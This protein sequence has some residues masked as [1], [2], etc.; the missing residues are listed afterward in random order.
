MATEDLKSG[1][2]KQS[3]PHS[4]EKPSGDNKGGAAWKSDCCKMSDACCGYVSSH[5][6]QTM[7]YAILAIGLFLLLFSNEWLGGLLIGAVI[8]CVFSSEIIAYARNLRNLFSGGG[9]QVRL[10]VLTGLAIG[11]L[12][13]LP[14]IFVGGVVVAAL[15]QIFCKTSE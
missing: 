3:G 5:K 11:I 2:N 4:S 12:I 1:K 14:G 6:Q 9:D 13:A 10:V 15:K 8:G 7:T